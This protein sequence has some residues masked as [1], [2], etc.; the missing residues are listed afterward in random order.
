MTE[1]H[2]HIL[3][4]AAL[5][6]IVILAVAGFGWWDWATRYEVGWFAAFIAC[7]YAAREAP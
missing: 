1:A 7:A 6:F 5:V 2:R 3:R 4:L